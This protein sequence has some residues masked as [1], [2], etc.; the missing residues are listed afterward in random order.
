MRRLFWPVVLLA[1][2]NPLSRCEALQ[3][4]RRRDAVVRPAVEYVIPLSSAP[5]DI[6]ARELKLNELQKT[7]VG[8]TH[9]QLQEEMSSLFAP[10]APASPSGV[11]DVMMK[12]D[13]SVQKADAEILAVLTAD[14]KSRTAP[15]LRAL[16]NVQSLRI[17]LA[18]YSDLGFSPD[19][20]KKFTVLSRDLA[21][22]RQQLQEDMRTAVQAQD[23]ARLGEILSKLR[24]DGKPDPRTIALLT[25]EQK[26]KLENYLK[27]HPRRPLLRGTFGS[28]VNLNDPAAQQ[29]V[30]RPF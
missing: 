15:L 24:I 27:L 17:P 2:V 9:A 4:Q 14:Q 29:P 10:S 28:P 1:V 23:T 25:P 21:A 18:L 13:R 8:K 30:N 5:V 26:D 16:T 11:T 12:R 22:E 6:L 7:A 3:I 20:L 19:Q